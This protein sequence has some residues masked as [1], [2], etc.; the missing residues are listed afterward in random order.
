MPQTRRRR[1]APVS[2]GTATHTAVLKAP[3][4][5]RPVVTKFLWGTATLG[6][7]RMEWH[8]AV[9]ALIM[10]CNWS[11]G[12][13][14]PFNYGVADACNLIVHE[15]LKGKWEWVWFLEDDTLPPPP[16][17]LLLS[18]HMRD[19][20]IPIISGLYHIKGT[21]EP[22]IYRGRGTGAYYPGKGRWHYGD[23]V[24]CDGVPMGCLMVHRSIFDVMAQDAEEYTLR[25]MGETT[26]LKRIFVTP[27]D[28]WIDSGTGAYQMK[29]GTQ[30][31]YWC[32][33]IIRKDVLRRAGWKRIAQQK[34]PMLVDTRIACGHIDR[35]TGQIW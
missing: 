30:D 22:L 9:S 34:W 10:P 21:Q 8:N 29:V 25:N 27:R 13:V 23:L 33:E 26:K 20:Q 19:G 24:W 15:A 1:G 4:N 11:S 16:T 35:S 18:E 17:L 5:D 14:T 6:N 12:R 3:V 32:D 7:I 31:L 2:H 28:Y